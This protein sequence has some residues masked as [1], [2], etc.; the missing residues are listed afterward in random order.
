MTTNQSALSCRSHP[1]L[2]PILTVSWQIGNGG[3]MNAPGDIALG[4]RRST[5]AL[6]VLSH[7]RSFTAGREAAVGGRGAPEVVGIG[8]SR[9]LLG[10][11]ERNRSLPI[12]VLVVFVTCRLRSIVHHCLLHG[13]ATQRLVD[14]YIGL[15]P[16]TCVVDTA[17]LDIGQSSMQVRNDL[18]SSLAR[19]RQSHRRRYPRRAGAGPAFR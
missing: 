8:F 6:V 19:P 2:L 11:V 5:R 13:R 7:P 10:L 1:D 15:C 17:R 4:I 9:S 16:R 14:A 3:M 12:F 18:P